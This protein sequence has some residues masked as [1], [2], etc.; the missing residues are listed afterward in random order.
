MKTRAIL[1]AFLVIFLAIGAGEAFAQDVQVPEEE[2]NEKRAQ[3]GMKFVSLSVDPRA[4]AL[5]NAVTTLHLGSA[6]V[7]YNPSALAKMSGFGNVAF[8]Q[9]QWIADISYN[10]ASLALRPANGAYGVVGLS[11]RS[12]DYGDLERTRRADNEAGYVTLPA[13]SPSGIAV[14]ITY[15]RTI[16]DRF[17]VGGSAKYVRQDLGEGSLGLN[18]GGGVISKEYTLNTA[19]FDFGVMY[20][21]GF[22]SLTFAMNARN[23]SP[24]IE[25][26]EESFELPLTL[27]VGLSMDMLDLLTPNL[28]DQHS[29]LL[30]VDTAHPRDFSETVSFGG[31]YSFMDVVAFRAGYTYP[32]EEQGISLGAGLH[33]GFSGLDLRADYAYTRFGIFG[34]VN[35]I[36][37]QLGF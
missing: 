20:S 33:Y 19:A 23:F 11:L 36:G 27:S 16:T 34:N 26:I 29:F 4:A 10:Q 15:A 24:A 37:V 22:R 31:E 7:F 25:Y 32:A 9:V 21:P 8:G 1:S 12:V 14:G 2:E 13:Y 28:T 5:G 6:S 30:A 17:S 3:T 18:D 35:R